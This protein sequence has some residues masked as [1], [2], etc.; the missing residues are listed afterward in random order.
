[1]GGN[2]LGATIGSVFA[3]TTCL[4]AYMG[5]QDQGDVSLYQNSDPVSDFQFGRG[6]M[7]IDGEN[8]LHED[9]NNLGSIQTEVPPIE[10]TIDPKDYVWTQEVEIQT[11]PVLVPG[12]FGLTPNGQ[13]CNIFKAREWL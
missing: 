4:M 12:D 10:I 1:M 3:L 2:R 5:N 7:S 8:S 6:L 11:E 9:Q 13:P